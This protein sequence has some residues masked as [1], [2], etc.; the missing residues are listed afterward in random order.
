MQT[1]SATKTNYILLSHVLGRASP[2]GHILNRVRLEQAISRVL[3]LGSCKPFHIK[4]LKAIAGGAGFGD[5][6]YLFLK[7]L[8]KNTQQLRKKGRIVLVVDDLSDLDSQYLGRFCELTQELLRNGF[9]VVL[10]EPSG[11][12]SS[13]G[14]VQQVVTTDD[15]VHIYVSDLWCETGDAS[16]RGVAAVSP[17][18]R[19]T[20][21]GRDRAFRA[22]LGRF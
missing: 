22:S 8:T 7:F 21:Q 14:A 10:S 15:V 1:K 13:L 12:M 6:S 5:S 19:S 2:D 17:I 9:E 11:A 18:S 16:L 20:R 4:T 3:G